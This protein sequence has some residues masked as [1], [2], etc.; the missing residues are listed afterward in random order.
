M[1]VVLRISTSNGGTPRS[2]DTV[3]WVGTA[4]PT[5]TGRTF[6]GTLGC[7]D[8]DPELDL[9]T[10]RSL[11]SLVT[12]ARVLAPNTRVFIVVGGFHPPPMAGGSGDRGA[13]ELSIT[14]SPAVAMGA[15][16]DPAGLTNR[17]DTGL[18]CLATT[19][20][21]ATGTCRMPGT[22]AGTQCRGTVPNCDVGL[23]CS[24]EAA[25]TMGVCLATAMADMRCDARSRC[26][27]GYFCANTTFGAATGTCRR[28][29]TVNGSACRPVGAMG[30]RCDSPL[31]CSSDVDPTDATPTCVRAAVLGMPCDTVSS[32][33]PMGSTCVTPTNGTTVGTCAADGTAIRSRCRASGT[34][35]DMGAECITLGEGAAA[36][37]FCLRRSMTN[38]GCGPGLQ[39]PDMDTCYLND[40]SNREE[41]LCGAPSMAGGACADTAPRCAG[42]LTCSAA[43]MGGLCGTSSTMVGA[44][45][46]RLRARCGEGY[47]CVYTTSQTMGTCQADGSVAGADCRAGDMPCATGLT[48]SGSVFNGGVCQRASTA[49]CDP[50]N[51]STRCPAMQYCL[52]TAF[53]A[54]TCTGG[55]TM[56]ME[57]NDN[58][59]DVMARA[60]TTGTLIRGAL[61]R[62]DVDCVAVTVPMGGSIVANVSDGNGRCP[63]GFGG[64]M[65]LD[66]YN[67]DG[68]TVR[69]LISQNGPYSAGSCSNFDGQRATAFPY[70]NNLPAGTYYVC[71]RGINGTVGGT[72]VTT[73]AV[74]EYVL[75]VNPRPAM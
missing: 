50:I 16:C 13:F 39:C 24:N 51:G 64:R 41:G 20:G 54:G 72:A 43:G 73:N 27:D 46:D 66:M 17:C 10:G 26:P 14:E 44:A 65:A 62:F 35:C 11:S 47:T 52:A 15:E 45:C 29:G 67:T 56:E 6:S 25:P 71:V 33:C 53:N 31:V 7:N 9:P 36:Q 32:V 55:A 5:G 34:R 42:M 19:F 75:S 38:M 8:D 28:V 70:A 37:D 74:S 69:G 18:V 22:V 60:V 59:S 3:L 61:P 30:G 40:S 49:A 2:F 12:T 63:V 58:P 68:T 4:C 48:C 23:T 1:P 21:A 57:P